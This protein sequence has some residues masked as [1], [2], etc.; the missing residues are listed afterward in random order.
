MHLRPFEH[1]NTEFPFLW[2]L[3][4]IL[5]ISTYLNASQT[6]IL[7]YRAQIKNAVVISQSF[8]FS[9]AMHPIKAQAAQTLTIYSKKETNLGLI[10]ENNK[11]VILE[12][13]MK[14]G[15]HT[16]SHETVSDLKSNSLIE[17][18]LAPTYITVNFKKDYAI[19]TRLIQE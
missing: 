10:I 15:A 9:Q 19:I 12:F 5:F 7:S 2:G 6:F 4:F 14:Y 16:R 11:D 17:L 3:V 8:Q 1:L 18:T 13:L